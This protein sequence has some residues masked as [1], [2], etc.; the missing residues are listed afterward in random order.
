M[1]EHR[2]SPLFEPGGVIIAGASPHPGRFGT[3]ALHNLLRSGYAGRV[4]ATSRE[5]GAVLGIDTVTS[6]EAIPDGGADLVVVCTP[7]SQNAAL[8]R[9]C[10]AK[11]V[12][13]AFVA[14]AGYAEAGEE[15]KRA[16]AEL[17][18]VADD[19]GMLLAGPNGQ[20]LVSTP[21]S[22]CAQI[23]A[24]Y[25][26]RGTIA[27]ASQSGNLTSALMNH[28]TQSGI[29]VSRA[30]STGNGASLST[31]DYL[32]YF[33]ADAETRVSLAYVEGLE[34]GGGFLA[35]ARALTREKPLVLL[36]GGTSAAGQ[37]AARS[38][39]GSMATN[40]RL[41]DTACR[42]AG[43]TRA[44]SVEEAFDAAA[45][46][47]T[48]PLPRGPNVVVLTTVGGQGVLCADAIA[49]S[50]LRLPPL[51]D[52]LLATG[53]ALLPARW[54]RNNPI[55]TAA[56]ETRDT[57]PEL[58]ERIVQ[59]DAVDALIFLGIGI[60][61]NQAAMMRSGALY[62]KHDL[63]RIVEF[64]E[65]QDRRYAEAAAALS[66]SSGKPILVAS[67]LAVT[68]PQNPGAAA[69]RASGR[70]C[71][72]SPERAVRSL[73]QLWRYARHCRGE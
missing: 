53:D 67:E 7:V 6:V 61:S 32:D 29:G 13:A 21:Q 56:G 71:Y 20:G 49:A 66:A 27:I 43:V 26:P 12:R 28:A 38:H 46:F 23:V 63:D 2:L 33:A 14:A 48:Q 3:V 70:L 34:E 68:A 4:Y 18:A 5:G 39:T 25:P 40:E 73:D 17:V 51:P 60:Q 54:S 72:A 22:L 64:H 24:P 55:D 19:A 69:V 1:S 62:P 8:L 36:K 31:F 44:L 11:G 41:F 37:S 42:Q 50:D 15:G 47:A 16:E 45:T 9:A 10:A 30:I 52:E 35:R 58:M 65:R 57:V 59:H